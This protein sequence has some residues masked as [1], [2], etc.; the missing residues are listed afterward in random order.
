M[1]VTTA[2]YLLETGHTVTLVDRAT[3]LAAEGSH[4]NAGILH[5]G[6]AEPWNTPAAVRQLARSLVRADSV[7][8]VHP[9]R[10]PALAGWGMRF[11]WHCRRSSHDAVTEANTRLAAWSLTETAA[12]R[13][14]TGIA[15]DGAQHGSLRI[16]RDRASLEQARAA[17]AEVEALGVR[18]R[19]LTPAA[20]VEQEP[21]LA[22]IE[23]ELTGGIHYVDDAQGDAAAFTRALGEVVRARG[24]ALR[25]G[26]SVERL[27][28]DTNGVTGV[29]TDA[30]TIR[31]ERFV[32]ANGVD[33]PGLARGL[34]VAVPVEPCKG[35]S[36][37]LALDAIDAAPHTPVIDDARQVV[38]SRLGSRLRVTGMAELAG[39]DRRIRPAA[40][41][42][43]L[44]DGLANYPRLA[45]RVDR[46]A[47][48]PWAC[49]RPVSADGAPLLGA[50]RVPGLFVNTGAG[51][52]GWTFAAGAG[53]LVA[54]AVTGRTAS[55]ALPRVDPRRF[56]R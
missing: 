43:I 4:A 26:A 49:L 10:L 42:Q 45:G 21:A 50:T 35:Y 36:A 13:R 7:L 54:E 56:A 1:G 16:F 51:H 40:I 2:Y 29:V 47:A 46:N 53:R 44:T 39:Y 14:A 8:Q 6:H 3:E 48:Q 30:G 32:L 5:A 27:E 25:L 33:A 23:G 11:L 22:D 28:G 18:A 24:A 41:E 15:F 55:L 17:A 9:G 38:I 37:T 31:G 52:L 20:V 19:A 34:G 12:L